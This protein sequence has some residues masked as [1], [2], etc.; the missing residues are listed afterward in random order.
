MLKNLKLRKK[1]ILLFI[2][3]GLIPVIIM[4]FVSINASKNNIRKEIF[5]GNNLFLKSTAS[6]LN[7]YFDERTGDGRV[8]A[9]SKNIYNIINTYSESGK[10]SEVWKESYNDLH[11]FLAT[12][13]ESYNYETIFLTNENGEIIF[14]TDKSN[15]GIDL[16]ERD[17]IQ[18]TLNNKQNWSQLFYSENIKTN[19]I[20]LSTP[21]F[22]KGSSGKLIGTLNFVITQHIID[23]IV[24]DGVEILAKIG[25]AYLVKS[26][27]TLLT[28]TKLGDFTE[29]AALR[30]KIETKSVSML[31][32]AI[33]DRDFQYSNTDEYKN[34]L[35]NK[36]LGSVGVIQFGRDAVGL[37]IE[38]DSAEVFEDANFLQK[39]LIISI[40]VIIL[41]GILLVVYLS[42]LITKPLIKTNDML[43]DI[44]KGEGDLTKALSVNS[45]DELGILAKWFNLF[46]SKIRDVVIQVISNADVLAE[47]SEQLALAME[48]SNKGMEEIAREITVISDGLQNSASV[49]EEATA[50]T[51][52]IAS[53]SMIISEEA[54]NVFEKSEET[55]KAAEFGGDKLSEVVLAIDRVKQSSDNMYSVIKNLNDSSVQIGDIVAMITNISE[56]INL[57]ALNAAIEAARA[58]EHGRGFAVV[59]D[60]VRKLAEESK[61]SAHKITQLINDIKSQAETADK[62]VKEEYE[63]VEMSVKKA[64]D[65]NLQFKRILELMEQITSRIKNISDSSRKQ[66]EITKDMTKAMEEISVTTQNNANASQQ[67]SAGIEEQVSTFEEIG[68]SAEELNNMANNLKEETDKFKTK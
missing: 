45:N 6:Q 61:D 21:V 13:K 20:V 59:A 4:G 2:V 49:I 62:S 19:V 40:L 66:S 3:T 63:I 54:E 64:K 34:Y 28:N 35:N 51:Q 57:L 29:D 9:S 33:E 15:E 50:S 47:S 11:T 37:V 1:I 60:E 30:Q 52:E 36:V 39:S 55:L 18:E 7:A 42:D 48:Q 5:K 22:E 26:D 31:S 43:K 41:L 58:G 53:G 32:K 24:H 25:D 46:I 23:D 67:I 65:T 14:S 44:A 12:V 16:S 17:Y 38:V 68:A 56:Q 10:E 27:G 8:L